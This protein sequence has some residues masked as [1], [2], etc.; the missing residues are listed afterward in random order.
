MS[1]HISGPKGYSARYFVTYGRS[2]KMVWA[3]EYAAPNGDVIYRHDLETGR[4]PLLGKP[5]NRAKAEKLTRAGLQETI[6]VEERHQRFA[7]GGKKRHSKTSTSKLPHQMTPETVKY[8]NEVK[9]RA[10]RS[11][12][13]ICIQL[14]DGTAWG[15]DQYGHTLYAKNSDVCVS[16]LV[17][18]TQKWRKTH[19]KAALQAQVDELNRMLK[20]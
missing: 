8:Q 13:I 11:R 5:E 1:L 3:A 19:P 17:S 18:G 15:V 10:R 16:K 4:G 6:G 9:D 20:E 7:A 14:P 2:N 12:Q